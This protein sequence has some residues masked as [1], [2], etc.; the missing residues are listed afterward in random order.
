MIPWTHKHTRALT[1]MHA[2]PFIVV[3]I[4]IKKA[5]GARFF[6][7]IGLDIIFMS[8]LT[9]HAARSLVQTITNPEAKIAEKYTARKRWDRTMY[10]CAGA[11]FLLCFRHHAILSL[12]I[13]MLIIYG[14]Y[15]I[16]RFISRH[17]PKF[18]SH[19]DRHPPQ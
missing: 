11:E 8:I 18:S 7:F 3:L 12:L 4:L 13:G 5:L 10:L 9:F 1:T 16:T 15:R 2:V 14:L 17:L 6:S 19:H